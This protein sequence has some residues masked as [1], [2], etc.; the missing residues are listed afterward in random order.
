M[1]WAASTIERAVKRREPGLVNY[2]VA[3][4]KK[5]L[6]GC[7]VM[8]VGGY[9]APADGSTTGQ[10]FLG[11]AES[12]VDNT[13]TGHVAGGKSINIWQTGRFEMV[14]SGTVTQADVG[15]VFMLD[16]TANGN[17]YTVR[18]VDEGDPGTYVR[19]G[20]CTRYISSALVEIDITGYAGQNVSSAS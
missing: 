14:A 19:M 18:N 9:A 12:T 2:P 17:D 1:T 13:L 8:C 5:I 11:I 20:V 3:D 16:T 10:T 15:A 6:K 4:N 7:V